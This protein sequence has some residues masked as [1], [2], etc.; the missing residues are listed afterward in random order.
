MQR[1]LQHGIIAALRNNE[2]ASRAEVRETDRNG[3]PGVLILEVEAA[4]KEASSATVTLYS[5]K[6]KNIFF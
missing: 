5:L 2:K 3:V 6:Q 4:M 1:S